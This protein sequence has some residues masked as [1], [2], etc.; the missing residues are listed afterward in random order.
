[1]I[2]YFLI[3][4]VWLIHAEYSYNKMGEELNNFRRLR[5]FL[6]WPITLIAFIWGV[7]DYLFNK[8]NE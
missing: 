5:Y 7:I 6:F 1:M 8:E 2:T 4:L 3:G